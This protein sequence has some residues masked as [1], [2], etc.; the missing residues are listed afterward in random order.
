MNNNKPKIL[1]IGPTPPPF[2]GPE[3]SM[4]Q[5]LESDVL[6]NAFQILFLKTNFRTDNTKK[7][8]LDLFMISNFFKFLFVFFFLY[9][10]CF[11]R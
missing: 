7:G 1:F 9:R 6:N 10:M 5:F 3:L 4:Q 8:K 11:W 2:S